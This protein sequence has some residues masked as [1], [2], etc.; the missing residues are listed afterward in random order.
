M[1]GAGGDEALDG[2]DGLDAAAGADG[3]A[4]ERSGSAA[5]IELA[6]QRP[7]LQESVNEARV[8]N[9]SGSGG[10][11]GFHAKSSG[12]GEARAIPSQYAFFAKSR[13][14][15]AAAKSFAERG[16]RLT[17]IRFFHQLPGNIPAGDEVVNAFQKFL[18][19]G[20]GFVQVRD[21]GNAGGARPACSGSRRSRIVAI[22]VKSAGSDNPLV[23]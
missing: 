23:I 11:H 12:V 6:L 19:A 16:E 15:K 18:D 5:E 2:V 7:A 10:I 8:K 4:V 21:D 13:R 1:A 14:G 9:I 17:Q 20:I 22:D 3:S